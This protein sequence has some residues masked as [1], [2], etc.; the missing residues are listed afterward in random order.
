MVV[1]IVD[2]GATLDRCLGALNEQVGGPELEVIVPWDDSVQ[3]I[4]E[5]ERRYSRFRFLALG[6]STLS[7]PSRLPR[8]SMSCSTGGEPRDWQ[9]PEVS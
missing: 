6:R 2:G 9:S 7:G 8:A 1:T 5:L 4:A 3:G